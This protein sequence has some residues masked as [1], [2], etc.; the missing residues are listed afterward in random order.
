MSGIEG[1]VLSV[2]GIA[3]FQLLQDADLYLAC[4][5]IL[6]DSTNDLDCDSLVGLGVDSLHD[7]PKRPLTQ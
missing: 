3:L 2:E 7:F 6:R 1:N 5:P 4:I